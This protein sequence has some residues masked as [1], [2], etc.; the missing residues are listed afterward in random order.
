MHSTE[1][2]LWRRNEG[3]AEVQ[4]VRWPQRY[5]IAFDDSQQS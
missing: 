5:L 4:T 3:K 1:T 2:L